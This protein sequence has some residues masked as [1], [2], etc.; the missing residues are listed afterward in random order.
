MKQMIS[1]LK[2]HFSLKTILAQ[3]YDPSSLYQTG[4]SQT[5]RVRLVKIL[6]AQLA[7]Q[8]ESHPIFLTYELTLLN[9]H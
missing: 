1:D 2:F 4:A 3:E 8:L 6:N 7:F 9:S 5:P